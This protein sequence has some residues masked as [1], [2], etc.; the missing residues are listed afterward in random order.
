MGF[1]QKIAQDLVV[2]GRNKYNYYKSFDFDKMT[3]EDMVAFRKVNKISVSDAIEAIERYETKHKTTIKQSENEKEYFERI[4]NPKVKTLSRKMSYEEFKKALYVEFNKEYFRLNNRRYKMDGDY[5]ENIKPI[6]YYYMGDYENFINCQNVLKNKHWVPSLKKGLLLVGNYGNGKSSTMEVFSNI[7][8]NTVRHFEMIGAQDFVDQYSFLR[9]DPKSQQILYSKV[10]N[11]PYL[12]DDIIR[13]I[14][15]QNYG[16][17]NL[18]EHVLEQKHKKNV[19]THATMN[20]KKD[21]N[22]RTIEDLELALNQ[23]GERYDGYMYDRA[24]AMFNVIHFKGKS[25]R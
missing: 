8:K 3:T 14:D 17:K 2:I 15:A 20:Y 23:I 6:F 1:A 7:T 5:L 9:N 10:I 12:L 13:E 11:Y 16:R 4:R 22:K 19:L 21:S 18:V 25:L 24:T